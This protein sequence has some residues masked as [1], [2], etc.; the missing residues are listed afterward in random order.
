MLPFPPE[1][2]TGSKMTGP[3][4]RIGRGMPSR[5]SAAL[6]LLAGLLLALPAR[7]EEQAAVGTLRIGLAA[8]PTSL[9]PHQHNFAPNLTVAL[10]LYDPL[11]WRAADGSSLQ[12]RLAQSW[13][14]V[15]GQV[16]A[17]RLRGDVRFHDGRRLTSRDVVY[18]Y[19][20]ADAVHGSRLSFAPVLRD[21]LQ[22]SPDGPGGVRVTVSRRF[23]EPPLVLAGIAIVAAPAD[24]PASA[25]FR[26]SGCIDGNGRALPSTRETGLPVGT[27]PY[28]LDPPDQSDLGR[29]T[30]RGNPDYWGGPPRWPSVRLQVIE[31]D[32]RRARALA[33]G[34]ADVVEQVPPG[35]VAA[36]QASGARVVSGNSNRL[37]YLQME[38]R[39]DDLS[40]LEA[41]GRNPFKDV[42]VRQAISLVIDRQALAERVMGGFATPVWQLVRSDMQGYAADLGTGH[43]L[44]AAHLLMQEAGYGDGFAVRLL[45]P[46]GRYANDRRVAEAVGAML[47][48]LGIRVTVQ[49]LPSADFFVVR[50]RE[51]AAFFLAGNAVSTGMTAVRALVLSPDPD[52]GRGT[53]NHGGYSNP[54][55][56]RLFDNAM[57]ATGD[58][59]QDRLIADANR[60]ASRTVAIIPLFYERTV[61]GLRRDLAIRLRPDQ[62]T[63]A[64]AVT[65]Q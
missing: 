45:A 11:I 44:A 36:L 63:L 37:I 25:E 59:E 47:L 30:L 16:W 6:F 57:A 52:R 58:G 3:D 39:R 19:C 46:D 64:E 43:D 12:P 13:Q 5:Y 15:T 32:Q 54:R 31:D 9:D 51:Q 38:Q 41:G 18:S 20:R 60:I 7:G 65:P 34:Q 1:L 55:V 4:D 8:E 2:A 56:D 27:G 29:I 40:D 49:A 24:F 28:L 23:A 14:A 17:F 50:T 35:S 53:S 21:I 42:R 61:W 22:V 26:Q 10:H 48:P 33:D 62:L